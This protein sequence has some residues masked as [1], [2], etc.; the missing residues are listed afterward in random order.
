LAVVNNKKLQVKDKVRTSISDN[1][2]YPKFCELAAKKDDVFSSFRSAPIYVE[3]LEHVSYNFAKQY[4][5]KF[6]ESNNEVIM[7]NLELFKS[8]DKIG[9]PDIKKFKSPVGMMSP[10]TTRYISILNDIY[11]IFGDMSG[12]KFTEVGAGYG[13]QSKIIHNAFNVSEYVIVDLDEACPRII[14]K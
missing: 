14:F 3:T 4:V 11:N 6:L 8:N 5:S 9:F 13:G 10:T 12:W 7:S 1:I 2:N